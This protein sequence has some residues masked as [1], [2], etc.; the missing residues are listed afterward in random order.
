MCNQ[1]VYL[2]STSSMPFWLDIEKVGVQS[3]LDI[4]LDTNY[5]SALKGLGNEFLRGYI[6]L[7]EGE[8]DPRNLLLAFSIARVILIEF[9]ISN[10]V[11]VCNQDNLSAIAHNCHRTCSISH[12]A[13]SPSAFGLRQ[14]ILM[15]SPQMI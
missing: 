8:K 11:D 9:D 15:A 10:H 6:G 7:A 3:I 12:S 1:L 2:F 14:M 13:T 5:L 4:F